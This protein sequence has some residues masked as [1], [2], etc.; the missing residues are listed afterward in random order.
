MNVGVSSDVTR[1]VFLFLGGLDFG[2]F[3]M[4]L[5]AFLCI[6]WAFIAGTLLF[7]DLLNPDASL[8]TPIG[9]R[10]PMGVFMWGCG[11]KSC[12]K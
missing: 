1:N 12:P 11:L 6:L 8:N 3:P 5:G 10:W 7:G 9:L 2:I 4:V